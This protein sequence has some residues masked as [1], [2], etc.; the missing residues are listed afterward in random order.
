MREIHLRTRTNTFGSSVR[1]VLCAIHDYLQSNG[2]YITT[3]IITGN[4]AE[5]AGESLR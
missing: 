4:D 3:P 1:S 5:G 2:L